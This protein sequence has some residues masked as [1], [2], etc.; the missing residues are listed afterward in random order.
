MEIKK[1]G[2]PLT[3]LYCAKGEQ[4]EALVIEYR[5]E[6]FQKQM[7]GYIDIKH[8]NN[9]PVAIV[10]LIGATDEENFINEEPDHIIFDENNEPQ[11]RINGNFIITGSYNNNL[12]SLSDEMFEKYYNML[13]EPMLPEQDNFLEP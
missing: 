5:N 11:I 13:N 6:A 12:N 8:F 10:C 1:I 3:V 7:N 2:E 9:D 4:A